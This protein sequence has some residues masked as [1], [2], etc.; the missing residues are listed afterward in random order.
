MLSLENMLSHELQTKLEWGKLVAR[1]FVA[2]SPDLLDIPREWWRRARL[3]FQTDSASNHGVTF[4]G[5][6]VAEAEAQP[7]SPALLPI[8]QQPDTRPIIQAIDKPASDADPATRPRN[9]KNRLGRPPSYDWLPFHH[10]VSQIMLDDGTNHT[11]ASFR[12]AVMEWVTENMD[13][14][15]AQETIDRQLVTRVSP[16]QFGG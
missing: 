1:G 2:G 4:S 9:V 6:V 10:Y 11:W 12:R 3:D 13:P 8:A 16:E 14:A 5:I 7:P 15:P